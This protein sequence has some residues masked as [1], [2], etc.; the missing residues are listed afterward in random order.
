MSDLIAQDVYSAPYRK[1]VTRLGDAQLIASRTTSAQIGRSGT[2]CAERGDTFGFA[3]QLAPLGGDEFWSDQGYMR[4]PY[5]PR[6]SIHIADM[7][8]GGTVRFADTAFDCLNV[9]I[10][11]AALRE[12]AERNGS[13]TVA[14]LRVRDPWTT[15]DPFV[16]SLERAL[17][18]TLDEAQF[19]DS[20]ASEHLIL[21]LL[22]HLAI[23]YGGMRP[24]AGALNGALSP[25]KLR[26]AQAI[27]LEELTQPIS[28]ADLARLCDL[29]PSHFSRAFKRATGQS[30]SLW[31]ARQRVSRAKDFLR[32][33]ELTLAE[34][35]YGCG[36]ADQSHFTRT[37][38]RHVGQPP[39]VWRRLRS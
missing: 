10:P 1:L 22:S 27:M 28:L 19:A 6:G 32:R 14:E 4:L 35:A 15:Q 7:R 37:F 2:V 31:L 11:A 8:A 21:T 39:G 38:S 29:S 20:L 33:S 13:T 36:F 24:A 34:I 12:F 9:A 17:I 3:Y 26:L 25:S 18:Y 5:V 16:T 23:T 30:P